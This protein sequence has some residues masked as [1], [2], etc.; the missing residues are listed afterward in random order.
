MDPQLQELAME[1]AKAIE[2]RLDQFEQRVE[3]R[4]QMHFENLG[5]LVKVSAEGYGANLGKIERELADLNRKMDTKL[6]DHDSVLVNHSTRITT[7]E[8]SKR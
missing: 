7:L 4:M 8:Q 3:Q 2:G 1:I 6:G 5:E